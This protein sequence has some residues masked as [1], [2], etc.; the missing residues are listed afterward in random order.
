MFILGIETTGANCSVALLDSK[1]N[2]TE[3]SSKEVLNHLQT[4]T[5]MIEEL[6]TKCKLQLGDID[7]IATSV[8]PGSFTGIRIG[9]STARALSQATGIKLVAVSTL[10]AFGCSECEEHG[11]ICPVFDARRNQ[12]YAG[13]YK[14]HEEMIA[15]GPYMLDEFLDKLEEENDI[16]FVGDGLKVYEEKIIQWAAEKNKKITTELKFQTAGGVV[17]MAR[18]MLG[19]PE[20][21][22]GEINLGYNELEPNYMRLPEAERKMKEKN[23]KNRC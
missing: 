16:Y 8:G 15:G 4:L 22:R 17:E 11:L 18:N 12:V 5:P 19:S 20:E 3:I 2:I 6:L 23:E 21:F 7:A 9:V 10:L 14:D 1:G 13:A